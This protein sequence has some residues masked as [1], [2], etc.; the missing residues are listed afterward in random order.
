MA[1]AVAETPPEGLNAYWL[2]VWSWAL[3]TMKEQGSWGYEL[4]PLLDGYVSALMDHEDC[5]D[6]GPTGRAGADRAM[7]RASGLADQ[8]CLTPRGR[9]AAGIGTDDASVDP[10][11]GF[12]PED[13]LEKRRSRGA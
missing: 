10:F 12:T 8:L 13:E 1:R 7:K 6:D 5:V 9:K 3:K 11:A 2:G 4:K